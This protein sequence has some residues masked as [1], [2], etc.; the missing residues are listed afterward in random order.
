M[1]L[2]VKGRFELQIIPAGVVGPL[3]SIQINEYCHIV[4]GFLTV[5]VYT[6]SCPLLPLASNK[7]EILVLFDTCTAPCT[8]GLI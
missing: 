5:S 8:T 3:F 1:F 6:C 2:R 4:S 7:A